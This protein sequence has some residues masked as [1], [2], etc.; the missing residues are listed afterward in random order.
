MPVPRLGDPE[1]GVGEKGSWLV[2]AVGESGRSRVC[3]CDD[4]GGSYSERCCFRDCE[5]DIGCLLV[6][7][8][9]WKGGGLLFCFDDGG[10]WCVDGRV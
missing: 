7:C 10:Y 9:C 4:E 1:P 5:M 3:I 2:T 8:C 6:V